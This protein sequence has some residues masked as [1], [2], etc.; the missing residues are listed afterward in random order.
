[1]LNHMLFNMLYNITDIYELTFHLD[2]LSTP[3]GQ[4]VQSD[5]T[6]CPVREIMLFNMLYNITDI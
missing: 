6:S 4:A 1:M 2:K 5:W 3:S